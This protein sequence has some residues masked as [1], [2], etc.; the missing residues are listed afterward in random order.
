[1]EQSWCVQWRS[2][3]T[4]DAVSIKYSREVPTKIEGVQCAGVIS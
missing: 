1:M 3:S 4:V 2:L